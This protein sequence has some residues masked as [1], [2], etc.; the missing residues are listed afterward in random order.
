M[1]LGRCR[2]CILLNALCDNQELGCE[3]CFNEDEQNEQGIYVL[4]KEFPCR[5]ENEVTEGFEEAFRFVLQVADGVWILHTDGDVFF[6]L[7]IDFTQ[8]GLE[9]I[10][11]HAIMDLSYFK[12]DDLG[13]RNMKFLKQFDTITTRWGGQFET[14][15]EDTIR[16]AA[17]YQKSTFLQAG[18]TKVDD[19]WLV[20][21]ALRCLVISHDIFEVGTNLAIRG[22]LDDGMPDYY[23][24]TEPELCHGRNGNCQL[25]ALIEIIRLGGAEDVPPDRKHPADTPCSLLQVTLQTAQRLLLRG[26]PHSW[27]A[28]FYAVGLLQLVCNDLNCH[29]TSAFQLAQKRVISAVQS[30]VEL[31]LYCCGDLHPLRTK[32]DIEWYSLMVG[33]DAKLQIEHYQTQ[34]DM[35]LEN[36]R[37]RDRVFCTEDFLRHLDNYIHGFIM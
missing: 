27:P 8:L 19:E 31:F 33:A 26:R 32:L 24:A 13:I 7:N 28:V 34:H 2:K 5:R 12:D 37:H 1:E 30:L 10:A 6:E 14:L 23:Q 35:W 15:S 36:R 20:L 22:C 25:I 11:D 18:D 9:V 16:R 29:F 3:R 17:D 21:N 4:A